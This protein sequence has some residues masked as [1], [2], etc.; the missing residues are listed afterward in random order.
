MSRK[1]SL[2]LLLP[3]LAFMLLLQLFSPAPPG[4]T[5]SYGGQGTRAFAAFL[6]E[7]L[8][9]VTPFMHSFDKLPKRGNNI[10]FVISPQTFFQAT[11]LL[12]WVRKGNTLALF[13]PFNKD[14]EYLLRSIGAPSPRIIDTPW[15][16]IL[17]RWTSRGAQ[18]NCA[19]K[20]PACLNSQEVSRSLLLFPSSDL[21]PSWQTVAA[22][23][24]GS[25]ISV[26]K[27]GL[28]EI[29]LFAGNE[30]IQNDEIDRL[31]NLSFLFSLSKNKDHV[32][33]DEFHHGFVEPSN[34]ELSEQRTHI[35]T[36]MS[37]L[38]LVGFLFM[39]SRS[40]RPGPIVL[41]E[42]RD[43]SFARNLFRVHG[44]ILEEQNCFSPL[45]HY[46]SGWKKKAELRFHLEKS[47]GIPEIIPAIRPQLSW[48]EEKLESLGLAIA[49]LNQA[50]DGIKESYDQDID[51][52]EEAL[53]TPKSKPQRQ[54]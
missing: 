27:E 54:D 46:L 14:Q 22:T 31:D 4:S 18:V 45:K 41:V 5:F 42:K 52:L 13:G 23:D 10:L 28:G 36:L 17:S 7:R 16:L 40:I 34:E 38:L 3:F 53:R 50:Q 29:W 15:N 47:I 30:L 49:R 12:D 43:I 9:N 20:H 26:L 2:F 44:Q 37:Y 11:E 19:T 35:Y 24:S 48:E 51:I 8:K 25:V 33:F 1:R 32:L 39:I 6:E 21:S